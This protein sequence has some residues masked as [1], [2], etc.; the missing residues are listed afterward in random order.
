MLLKSL[1]LKQDRQY[2]YYVTMRCVCAT[3]VAEE[4]Q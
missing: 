2:M 3:I 4:Y 1:Q